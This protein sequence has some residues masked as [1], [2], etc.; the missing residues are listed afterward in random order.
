M[1]NSRNLILHP[2]TVLTSTQLLAP[3]SAG[4]THLVEVD[5]GAVVLVAEEMVVTHTELSEV[6]RM[7]L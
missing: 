2:R 1:P 3:E 4:A 6:T 7:E 5:G